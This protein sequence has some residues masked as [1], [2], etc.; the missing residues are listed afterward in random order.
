[1]ASLDFST[2]EM[3]VTTESMLCAWLDVLEIFQRDLACTDV[4]NQIF[5]HS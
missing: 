2:F 1:M 3:L 5:F 4:S